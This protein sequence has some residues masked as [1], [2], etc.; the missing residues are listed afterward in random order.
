MSQTPQRGHQ[1]G[2]GLFSSTS[3]ISSS[4]NRNLNV[5]SP[6]SANSIVSSSPTALKFQ[7]T[8]NTLSPNNNNDGPPPVPPAVKLNNNIS[9]STKR[10]TSSPFIHTVGSSSV[11]LLDSRKNSLRLTTATT[12]PPAST[13]RSSLLPHQQQQ[14]QQ[15]QQ[16]HNPHR[17][18]LE[19]RGATR[20]HVYAAAA[21]NA[22]IAK[23]T[24]QLQDAIAYVSTENAMMEEVLSEPHHIVSN[25]DL[26]AIMKSVLAAASDSKSSAILQGRKPPVLRNVAKARGEA[27]ATTSSSSSSSSAAMM[28]PP[29]R[30][31]T[32]YLP[33]A[34]SSVPYAAL[35]QEQR[36]M[37]QRNKERQ[38]AY[39]RMI[40]DV[41]RQQLSFQESWGNLTK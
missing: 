3:S 37:M 1:P 41:E 26:A 24:R 16:Q 12:N 22:L 23:T 30:S 27:L 9:N 6:L 2:L 19:V 4:T 28:L 34:S 33:F 13:N 5:K 20:E 32:E 10:R 18:W 14:Q 35:Q 11:A 38:A 21:N 8:K 17:S 7:A 39:D 15:Q 25:N 31:G 29:D 40:L 36:D